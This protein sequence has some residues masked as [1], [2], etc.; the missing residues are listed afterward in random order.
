[1]DYTFIIM[2]LHPFG[3]IA[4]VKTQLEGKS[5]AIIII[6]NIRFRGKQSGKSSLIYLGERSWFT[7]SSVS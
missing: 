1:M 7:G 3:K 2:I 4:T 6:S 5:P